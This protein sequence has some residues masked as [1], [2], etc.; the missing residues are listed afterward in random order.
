MLRPHNQSTYAQYTIQVSDRDTV[1]KALA[2]NQIPSAVHYPTPIHLQPLFA[3][4]PLNATPYSLPYSEAMAKT[5]LSLPFHPYLQD[6]EIE[7]IAEVVIAAVTAV[8][9]ALPLYS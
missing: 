6:Q 8:S 4:L 1:V 5:V 9:G 2:Q 7:S 3:D